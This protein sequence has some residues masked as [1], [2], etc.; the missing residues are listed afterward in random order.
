M[1]FQELAIVVTTRPIPAEGVA[2]GARGTVLEVFKGGEAYLVE[3]SNDEGETLAMPVLE[4]ADL[5]AAPVE[6]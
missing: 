1:T 3:F 5:A 4:A 6:T 2:A